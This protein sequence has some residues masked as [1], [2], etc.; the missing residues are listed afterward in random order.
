[1]VSFSIATLLGIATHEIMRFFD[2]KS[3]A[4]ELDNSD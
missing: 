3:L 4:L 1:M 2:N